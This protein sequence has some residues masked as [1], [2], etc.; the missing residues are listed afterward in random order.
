[1]Q[2]FFSESPG[3]S[4]SGPVEVSFQ[5]LLPCHCSEGLVHLS[6]YFFLESAASILSILLFVPEAGK[7]RLHSA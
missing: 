1:M 6:R 7:F 5:F 4:F 2:H 3:F